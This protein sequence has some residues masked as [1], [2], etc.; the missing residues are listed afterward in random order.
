MKTKTEKTPL[1][2]AEACGPTSSPFVLCLKVNFRTGQ[3]V[4]TVSFRN[5]A[6]TSGKNTVTLR[7]TEK[8]F[9]RISWDPK[10]FPVALFLS[11]E[12]VVFSSDDVFSCV[13]TSDEVRACARACSQAQ[14][15]GI[16]TKAQGAK[17]SEEGFFMFF[18][19]IQLIQ[20]QK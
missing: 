10:R 11:A 7:S 12:R 6:T 17:T 3:K 2:M 13:A 19:I 18:L 8:P 5:S 4:C 14:S 16:S 1:V 15:H 9:S 20:N